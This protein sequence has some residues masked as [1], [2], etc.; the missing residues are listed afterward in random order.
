VQ[1]PD[2]I[3]CWQRVSPEITTSGWIEADDIARLAALGVRHVINL[4]LASHPASLADEGAL[5]ECCGMAYTHIPI[6]FDAPAEDHFE[7]FRDAL[8]DGERPVHIHCIANWRVSALLYRWH[9]DHAGMAEREAFGLMARQWNPAAHS[10]PD[11]PAWA[12][13]V[14]APAE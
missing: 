6:P 8:G 13:L 12:Q 7:A 5:V 10:H 9:R 1:D 2:D 4:A 14:G 3:T 11:A